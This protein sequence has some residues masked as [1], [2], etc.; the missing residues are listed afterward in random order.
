MNTSIIVAACVVAWLVA[1]M[2]ELWLDVRWHRRA[3]PAF[4]WHLD[5]RLDWPAVVMGG[6][7]LAVGVYHRYVNGRR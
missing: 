2:V 7:Y 6:F 4:E 5:Y 1:G 3:L